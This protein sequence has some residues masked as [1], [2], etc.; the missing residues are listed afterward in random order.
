MTAH[1][2]RPIDAGRTV[3]AA[4]AAQLHE[5]ILAG[6]LEPGARLPSIRE[7]ASSFGVSIAAIR[8]SLSAL[9]AAGLL[10][11]RHGRGTYVRERPPIQQPFAGWLS[12]GSDAD[13]LRGLIEARRVI[14]TRIAE[15]AAER[16]T[17]R[18][19]E[20]IAEA[21]RAMETAGSHLG[22]FVEADV[23]FHLR[24][25]E[26]AHSPVLQRIL[27]AL[28]TLLRQQIVIHIEANMTNPDYLRES[29]ARHRRLE[30]AITAGDVE[31]ALSAVHTLL[32][33]AE[34][35]AA[36][37]SGLVAPATDRP[38]ASD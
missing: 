14:E 18:E 28:A 22:P 1:G 26:A 7:L 4:V 34:R 12:F 8:E 9:E 27:A 24:I 35:F 23:A 10:D 20:A 2:I 30:T 36:R 16:R 5:L 19:A 11:V 25:A 3:P 15:L 21:M 31:A 33:A 17:A 32:D 29:L 38:S 6:E 37:R 13:E